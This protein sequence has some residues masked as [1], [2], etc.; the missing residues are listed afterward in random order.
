MTQKHDPDKNLDALISQLADTERALVE[1]VTPSR[2]IE[3]LTRKYDVDTRT[4]NQWVATV[5]R[6]WERLREG[7]PIEERRSQLVAMVENVYASAV[8]HS[9]IVRDSDGEPMLDPISG[10]VLEKRKPDRKAALAAVRLLADLDGAMAPQ[11]HQHQV[12]VALITAE[13]DKQPDDE[14]AASAGL[15]RGVLERAAQRALPAA[16]TASTGGAASPG[17]NG[18]STNGHRT[19]D[20]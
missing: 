10:R 13:L 7:V 5:R 12:A 1:L 11:K 17:G 6:R 19:G 18:H 9:E 14:L 2:V 16:S 8:N 15:A 4:A 20:N 3:A